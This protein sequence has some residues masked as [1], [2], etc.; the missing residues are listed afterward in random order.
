M[1][2]PIKTIRRETGLVEGICEHGV[3]HPLYGSIDWMDRDGPE[4]AKGS[5]GTHVCCGCCKSTEWEITTLK[6]SVRTANGI[7]MDHKKY[8]EKLKEA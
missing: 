3:G 6:E 7:I 2:K 4:G 1:T 8:I 5:W